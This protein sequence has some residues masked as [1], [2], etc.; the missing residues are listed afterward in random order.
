MNQQMEMRLQKRYKLLLSL[1]GSQN[2]SVKHVCWNLVLFYRSGKQSFRKH[3]QEAAWVLTVGQKQL[4]LQ[5]W[6]ILLELSGQ[7]HVCRI[8]I[9]IYIFLIFFVCANFS[10][11]KSQSHAVL[12]KVAE[13]DRREKTYRAW[14]KNGDLQPLFQVTETYPALLATSRKLGSEWLKCS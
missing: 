8:E 5:P 1:F 2:R 9:L 7:A 3:T 14:E 13:A 11:Q 10:F 12:R 6:L 4:Q